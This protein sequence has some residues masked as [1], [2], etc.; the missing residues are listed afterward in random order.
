MWAKPFSWDC[1][2]TAFIWLYKPLSTQHIIELLEINCCGLY[3]RDILTILTSVLLESVIT[4]LSLGIHGVFIKRE[5]IKLSTFK[6]IVCF[7]GILYYFKYVLNGKISFNKH[8]YWCLWGEVAALLSGR[9][10]PS[11]ALRVA[12][13]IFSSLLTVVWFY[14]LDLLSIVM[15]MVIV[16]LET[17]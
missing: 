6:R 8:S 15:L 12:Y 4:L 5:L 11:V 1:K 7:L 10:T 17:S 9:K 3:N 13:F 14:H 2:L 16:K